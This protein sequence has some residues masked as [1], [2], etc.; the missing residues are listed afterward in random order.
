MV[1]GERF[2]WAHLP[3]TGG[4][5]TRELFELFP[6]FVH[7]ADPGDTNDKH[8]TF[9]DRA[10]TVRGKTLAMNFRRLPAWVLSRA[11]HVAREGLWPDYTPEPMPAAAELAAS[12]LPDGR[13]QVFTADG[14][15]RI[16][17]WMRLEH[18]RHDF[19]A[20]VKEFHP[21]TPADERL[22]HE[23]PARDV[24]CYD[25]DPHNWFSASQLK[26]MYEAN[27]RW[28]TLERE[29]YGDLVI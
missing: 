24:A 26:Q 17:R 1:I 4:D 10:D 18:L 15:I 5:T 25:R 20:F 9:E 29:L 19:L 8:A 27:P 13:L 11:H 23:L 2:A 22:V 12:T 21:V 14:R 16:D 3:K 7:H 28:A 6:G